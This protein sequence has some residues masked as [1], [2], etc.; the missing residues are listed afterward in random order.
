MGAGGWPVFS[1]LADVWAAEKG[2]N[3]ITHGIAMRFNA[4]G[5]WGTPIWHPGYS[6]WAPGVFN[7]VP[8]GTQSWGRGYSNLGAHS[9]TWRQQNCIP[10]PHRVFPVVA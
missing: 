6:N 5:C 10:S 9:S 2:Q 7:F 3:G 1:A 8:R 4:G